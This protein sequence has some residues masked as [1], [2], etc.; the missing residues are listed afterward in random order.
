M[1]LSISAA[2]GASVAS[3]CLC[4][5]GGGTLRRSASSEGGLRGRALVYADKGAGERSVATLIAA[6][7]EHGL[8]AREILAPE[9][10]AGRWQHD[11]DVF[12]MPGGA[13][14]PYCSKLNGNG[15][16]SIRAFVEGGGS[17]L[18]V[19]A[20]GYYGSA[21]CEFEI[22]TALEVVGERELGF[23]PG[24]ARGAAFPGFLYA[25][26]T[27]SRAAELLLQPVP[28][29]H[30]ASPTFRDVPAPV[31][32]VVCYVNGG[33][34]FLAADGSVAEN[35]PGCEVLAWFADPEVAERISQAGSPTRRGCGQV[36]AAVC[37]TVGDGVAVL[38]GAHPELTAAALSTGAR[39][40]PA[41]KGPHQGFDDGGGLDPM[42]LGQLRDGE[43]GRRKL[44]ERL[45][46]AL[47][48]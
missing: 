8:A 19:C 27:G 7:R 30:A 12:A 15:N 18:G 32:S 22:G 5:R 40:A 21:R 29:E 43:D 48:L 41:V 42:V 38:T 13:D 45:L 26:E 37:C 2:A 11:C 44:F 35:V 31:D 1:A 33:C 36:A 6:L 39:P 25:K 47:R 28:D 14:L 24:I 16:D 20:G 3:L 34:G 23:F 9:V 4:R 46:L 17:F 10:V